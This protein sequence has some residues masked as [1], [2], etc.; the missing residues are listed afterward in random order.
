MQGPAHL[1]PLKVYGASLWSSMKERST[2]KRSM[3]FACIIYCTLTHAIRSQNNLLT[4]LG[5]EFSLDSRLPSLLIITGLV[6][7]RL[8][9]S[10]VK[11]AR[12][13]SP[14]STVLCIRHSPLL[15][16]TTSIALTSLQLQKDRQCFYSDCIVS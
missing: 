12:S 14:A 6:F 9:E 8:C 15:K 2:L 5:F 11:E 7:S 1:H 3:F 10:V 16:T 13:G 4:L